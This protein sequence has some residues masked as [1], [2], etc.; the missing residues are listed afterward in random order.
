MRT[1]DDRVVCG[2]DERFFDEAVAFGLVMVEGFAEIVG[3]CF[4]EGVGG[5]ILLVLAEHVAPCH[6]VSINLA[7]DDVEYRVNALQEHGDALKTVGVFDGDHGKIE[8]ARLLEV[9][10]LCYFYPVEVYLPAKT[11]CAQGGRLPVILGEPEIVLFRRNS[12]RAQAVEIKLLSVSGRGFKN[13]L[14]LP[15][16]VDAQRVLRISAVAGTLRWLHIDAAPR[17]LVKNPEE[18]GWIECPGA[19]FGRVGLHEKATLGHPVCLESRDYL[20]ER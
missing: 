12:K 9:R 15:V 2:H 5:E 7:P 10:E 3:V 16:L 11:P 19:Y 6:P 1:F 18:C 4:L 13:R 14:Q 17:P 20:L 8:S